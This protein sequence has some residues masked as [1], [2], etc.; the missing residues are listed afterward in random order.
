[1]PSSVSHQLV[2]HGCTAE[3]DRDPESA[4]HDPVAGLVGPFA[5][6]PPPT[7]QA[8]WSI[9]STLKS[10]TG[11][12]S[13]VFDALNLG[14]SVVGTATAAIAS[15]LTLLNKIKADLVTAQQPGT[16]LSAVQTDI[17]AQQR[18]LV[19]VLSSASFNG[20]NLLDGSAGTSPSA[21]DDDLDDDDDQDDVAVSH[22]SEP[23]FRSHPP[24]RPPH[25]RPGH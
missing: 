25:H 1:M 3:L 4:E 2:R 11:A 12:L 22:V 20:V 6:P 9:S 23:V 14:A 19:A 8:Y 10:D 15:T 5:S 18:S 16:S 21:Q 17:A 24:H 13:A 7:T